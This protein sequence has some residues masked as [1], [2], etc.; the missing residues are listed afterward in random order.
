MLF[1]FSTPGLFRH[2]WH[3][4]TVVFLH[5]CLICAALLTLMNTNSTFL[6]FSEM[7][8]GLVRN[9]TRGGLKIKDRQSSQYDCFTSVA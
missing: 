5:W 4:K 3:L 7:I 9:E 6:L 2:L 1:I 8:K